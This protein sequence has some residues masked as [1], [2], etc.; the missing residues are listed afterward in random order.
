MALDPAMHKL[1]MSIVDQYRP[2]PLALAAGP[3][4]DRCGGKCFCGLPCVLGDH[5]GKCRCID[6]RKR[7]E[8][9]HAR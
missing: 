6:E 4:E 8:L 2:A 3:R 1:V 7:A 9:P 5:G